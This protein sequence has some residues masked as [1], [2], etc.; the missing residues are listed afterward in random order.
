MGSEAS[1][2]TKTNP[3]SLS[4]SLSLGQTG[5]PRVATLLAVS[6]LLNSDISV[7]TAYTYPLLQTPITAERGLGQNWNSISIYKA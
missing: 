1:A 7:W 3:L 6:M 5:V 4:L 2:K